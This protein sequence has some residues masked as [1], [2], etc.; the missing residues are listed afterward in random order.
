MLNEGLQ[1]AS[2]SFKFLVKTYRI[3]QNY[4]GEGTLYVRE[5]ISSTLLL[6]ENSPIEG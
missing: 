2:A 6:V 1:R 3:D 4:H 5:D